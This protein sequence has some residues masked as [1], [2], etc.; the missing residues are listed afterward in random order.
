MSI[1][2]SAADMTPPARIP[3]GRVKH[4]EAAGELRARPGQWLRLTT[5]SSENAAWSFAHQITIGR[6]AAFRPAGDFEGASSGREVMA[7]YVG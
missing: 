5:A 6:R 4:L 2:I 1:D 7:R 3:A